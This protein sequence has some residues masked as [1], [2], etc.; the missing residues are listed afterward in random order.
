MRNARAKGRAFSR[1]RSHRK[2]INSINHIKKHKWI[3]T[4]KHI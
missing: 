2:Q 4:K 3:L 1:K